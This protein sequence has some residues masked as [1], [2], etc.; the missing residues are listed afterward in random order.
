MQEGAD[1]GALSHEDYLNG[2]GEKV[3]SKFSKPGK[4]SYCESL[5]ALSCAPSFWISTLHFSNNLYHDSASICSLVNC[6]FHFVTW[7][8]RLLLSFVC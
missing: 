6:I 5:L 2:P 1:A 7:E 3:S 4:Y 8:I